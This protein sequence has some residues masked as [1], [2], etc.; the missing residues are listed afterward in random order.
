MVAKKIAVF[1]ENWKKKRLPRL[2]SKE[3]ALA[4]RQVAE[5]PSSGLVPKAVLGHSDLRRMTLL[6]PHLWA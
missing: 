6:N 4:P 2:I 1:D 3:E 5:L